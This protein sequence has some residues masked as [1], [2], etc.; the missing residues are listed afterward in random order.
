[1]DLEDWP[2]PRFRERNIQRLETEIERNHQNAP[3]LPMPGD[4][5]QVEEYIFAKCMSKDDYLRTIAKVINAYNCKSKSAA[6][7]SA[8]QPSSFHSTT[9][10]L[11]TGVCTSGYRA[12]VPPDSQ[13][14]SAQARNPPVTTAP[15]VELKIDEDDWPAPRFRERH[16]QRL[17]PELA[18][19]R[20]NAPNLPV[21]GDA[22]QVEEYIFAKCMSKEDYLR[23]IEKV[24]NAISCNS[25]S[26]AVP[27]V[28]RQY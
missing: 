3:N 24:I 18:R 27:S 12:P 11:G 14:T 20:Q 5:R 7:P 22:R 26:A 13:P 16:I 25:K 17:E 4:A 21:P 23:T 1:M 19:N 28:L 8:I 15:K 2:A 9:A 6:V 10:V